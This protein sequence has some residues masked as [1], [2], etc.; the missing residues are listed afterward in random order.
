MGFHRLIGGVGPLLD[1]PVFSTLVVT[2]SQETVQGVLSFL[3][4][5]SFSP[6]HI[7]D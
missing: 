6:R 5:G 7:S 4:I 2:R 1:L 3:T